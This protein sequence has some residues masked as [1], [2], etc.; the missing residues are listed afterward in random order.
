MS[1]AGQNVLTVLLSS[2][3]DTHRMR[4]FFDP[5]S[6]NITPQYQGKVAA[7]LPSYDADETPQVMI[8]PQRM[9]YGINIQYS[10]RPTST[11]S[12]TVDFYLQDQYFDYDTVKTYFCFH[13]QA[14]LLNFGKEKVVQYEAKNEIHAGDSFACINEFCKQ[15]YTY[16]GMVQIH[17]PEVV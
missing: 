8:R 9:K 11:K 7:I 10:F 2:D 5:Y 6:R 17:H 1:V 3:E 16:L 4:M 13:C 12:D 14:Q 15:K